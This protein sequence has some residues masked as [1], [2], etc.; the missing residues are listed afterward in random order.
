MKTTWAR[1][2]PIALFSIVMSMTAPGD[3]GETE[4]TAAKLEQDPIELLVRNGVG[5]HGLIVVDLILKH[6]GS[7]PLNIPQRGAGRLHYELRDATGKVYHMTPTPL[8]GLPFEKEDLEIGA[9]SEHTLRCELRP[10]HWFDAP[11]PDMTHVFFL[12]KGVKP[13]TKGESVWAYPVK[14]TA[15]MTGATK[16]D[17]D[18]PQTYRSET[19]EVT[20]KAKQG[21]DQGG[22][23]E[24]EKP[25]SR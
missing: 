12:P 21:A 8:L 10:Q 7:A 22:P 13:Y 17:Q 1:P 5:H 3:Q 20:A 15:I 16:A 6:H 24:S 2:L 4:P 23:E 25:A 18:E 19:I 14:L 9:N 11:C